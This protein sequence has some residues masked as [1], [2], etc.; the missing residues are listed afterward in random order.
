M[1]T[2]TLRNAMVGNLTALGLL[3]GPAL[4]APPEASAVLPEDVRFFRMEMAGGEPIGAGPL[5]QVVI[6]HAEES[7]EAR[8]VR[9]APYQADAVTEFVQTLADGNRIVRR[10]SGTVARDSEG[11]TRRE[12][13]LAVVGPLLAEVPEHKAVFIDDPVAKASYVLEP[14]AKVARRRPR[15]AI[16]TDRSGGTGGKDEPGVERVIVRRGPGKETPEAGTFVKKLPEPQTESLGTRV[17][18]GVEATGTRSTV[19]IPAGEVGNERPLG[20][21]TERWYSADLQ[22]V[23]LSRH[24]DP[25]LGET[26]FRLE[27]IN[28]AEPDRALFEVPADYTVKEGGPGPRIE[29]QRRIVRH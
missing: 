6:M 20:V 9:G 10:A 1:R 14:Q 23:V 12:H 8:L 26:T 25:R 17:I 29:I 2:K 28:R 22:A 13:S 27:H 19:T 18:E 11:R 16:A 24:S 4:A 3:A 7:F 5:D 15:A 21:V